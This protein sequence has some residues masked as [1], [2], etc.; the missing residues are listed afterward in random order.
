VGIARTIHIARLVDARAV[1]AVGGPGSRCTNRAPT[2]PP[3]PGVRPFVGN[4]SWCAVSAVCGVREGAKGCPLP[5]GAS[6]CVRRC[7]NPTVPSSSPTPSSARLAGSGTGVTVGFRRKI[8][9][10]SSPVTHLRM[11]TVGRV[12]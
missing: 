4:G 8:A 7:A 3:S 12:A 9:I 10:M 11:A 2:L 6:Y 1:V 5:T